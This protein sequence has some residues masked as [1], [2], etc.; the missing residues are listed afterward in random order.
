MITSHLPRS[1]QRRDLVVA[2][3]VTVVEVLGL[4]TGPPA[5]TPSAALGSVGLLL[6]L[7]QGV[8]LLWRRTH[9]VAVLGVTTAAFV[10]YAVLV[11]P[12]PPDRKSTRLHS[13]PQI[14]PYAVSCY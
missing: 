10:A 5:S 13:S 14:A 6:A 12:V 3:M 4:R 9:P 2:G 1:W 11:V 7:A 8:P